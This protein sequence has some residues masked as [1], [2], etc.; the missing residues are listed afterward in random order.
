MNDAYKTP[1][2]R[3]KVNEYDKEMPKPYA[4][5]Q[6]TASLGRDTGD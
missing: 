2:S 4:A 1:L 3:Q 6:P 5:D